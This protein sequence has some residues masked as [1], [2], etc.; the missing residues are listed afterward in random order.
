MSFSGR[1]GGGGSGEPQSELTTIKHVP[2]LSLDPPPHG[3]SDS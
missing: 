1:D 2:D 3:E